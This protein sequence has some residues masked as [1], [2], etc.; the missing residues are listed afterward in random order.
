ML[1]NLV[2]CRSKATFFL[3]L[4]VPVYLCLS[5]VSGYAKNH[6]IAKGETLGIIARKYGLTISEIARHNGINNPNRVKVG[7]KINIPGKSVSISYTVKRG[8]TLSSIAK[9]VSYTHLTL[10][11]TPYV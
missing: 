10:P 5:Q 7:Q 8:D 3:I 11:T 9:T 6:T 1:I 4:V 2:K